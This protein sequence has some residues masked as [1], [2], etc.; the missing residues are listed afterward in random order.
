LLALLRSDR[1][2]DRYPIDP[3]NPVDTRRRDEAL[4]KAKQAAPLLGE[5][6]LPHLLQPL[7]ERRM[8]SQ[9][10][11]DILQRAP[12]DAHLQVYLTHSPS[13][14]SPTS[15]SV[16]NAT[17]I[18]DT[19]SVAAL[20]LVLRNPTTTLDT[21]CCAVRKLNLLAGDVD[22]VGD[23]IKA[24]V[25]LPLVDAMRTENAELRELATS[26][27]TAL[28]TAACRSGDERLLMRVSE[29]SGGA[30]DDLYGTILLQLMRA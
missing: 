13:P 16:T 29:D 8:T 15:W 30:L 9:Q 19:R 6:V 20:V 28:L 12:A 26:A 1:L 4:A 2:R 22:L 7:L 14:I 3:H 17:Q 10:L 18:K 23:M 25:I 24:G 11:W 21:M 5:Y 27:V